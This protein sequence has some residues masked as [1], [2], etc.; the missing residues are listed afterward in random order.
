MAFLILRSNVSIYSNDLSSERTKNTVPFG[1]FLM[2]IVKC[3]FLTTH[4]KDLLYDFSSLANLK[5]MPFAFQCQQIINVL[6]I[7]GK[8]FNFF[9]L[10]FPFFNI[11]SN[12][13]SGILR[14]KHK[15]ILYN[16]SI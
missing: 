6:I 11:K 9:L 3:K 14:C 16:Y 13:S 5:K 1:Q 4:S 15:H 2:P 12:V 8:Y 10:C 7:I